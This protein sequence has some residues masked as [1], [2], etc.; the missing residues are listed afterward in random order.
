M[1]FLS[2]GTLR[3]VTCRVCLFYLDVC[4]HVTYRR[5]V[6]SA[7]APKQVE[8]GQWTQKLLAEENIN[9]I[10]LVFCG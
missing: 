2:L 4:F 9:H 5:T 6:I 3:G 1:A 10:K 8:I 7:S